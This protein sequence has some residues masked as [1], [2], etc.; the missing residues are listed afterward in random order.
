[1]QL[2]PAVLRVVGGQLGGIDAGGALDVCPVRV[3]GVIDPI[4]VDITSCP[5]P[6]RFLLLYQLCGIRGLIMAD[7]LEVGTLVRVSSRLR[8]ILV[9]LYNWIPIIEEPRVRRYL[10]LI[11]VVIDTLHKHRLWIGI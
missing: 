9:L 6:F 7:A 11:L 2:R 1:M 3:S 4:N 10:L 5:N 8:A